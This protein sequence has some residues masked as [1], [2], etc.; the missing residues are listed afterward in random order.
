VRALRDNGAGEPDP[1]PKLTRALGPIAQRE[2]T[3][4]SRDATVEDLV[5]FSVRDGLD[6]LLLHDP[7]VRLDLGVEDIHQARIATRRLRANLRTLR[8]LLHRRTVDD[9]R[10][11]IRWAGQSLG[12]VRDLD[13]LRASFA[14]SLE[15]TPSPGGADIIAAVETERAAAHRCLVDAMRSLRWQSMLRMLDAAAVLPPLRTTVA[16]TDDARDRVPRLLRKSWRRLEGRVADASATPTGWHEVRKA[17]KS[18][19]YAVE[20]VEPLL[21]GAAQRLARDTERMQ[22]ELGRRQDDVVARAWLHDHGRAATL[23]PAAQRLACQYGDP[24]N[25]RP[26]QWRKL[27]KRARRSAREGGVSKVV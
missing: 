22:T 21:A 7:G 20:M 4:L 3:A 25:N 8:P 14:R 16:P 19:R 23:R 9:L 5:R 1:T 12:A 24:D 6:Q 11:E 13:V 18:T 17:A 15:R 27:W 2:T 26:P 10:A